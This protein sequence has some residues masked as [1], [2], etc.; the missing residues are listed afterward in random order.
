MK[1]PGAAVADGGF[2][3]GSSKVDFILL[4]NVKSSENK[5]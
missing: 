5:T 1:L 2:S 4:K 3:R